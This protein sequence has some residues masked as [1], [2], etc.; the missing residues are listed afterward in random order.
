MDS[1][2]IPGIATMRLRHWANLA[3]ALCL[4][5][6]VS[7]ASAQSL[8]A[9]DP[10]TGIALPEQPA[11]LL[12]EGE[13]P[14]PAALPPTLPDVVVTVEAAP[15]AEAEMV[16]GTVAPSE[17]PPSGLPGFSLPATAATSPGVVDEPVE[18][19]RAHV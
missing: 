4:M 5:L 13:K 1:A 9:I 14:A 8:P 10:V 17:P 7:A 16:T 18:I 15:A 11:L 19:G 2:I 6:G 3:S 12:L